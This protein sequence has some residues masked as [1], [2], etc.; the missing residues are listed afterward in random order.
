MNVNK[1]TGGEL[2]QRSSLTLIANMAFKIKQVAK[3]QQLFS[4]FLSTTSMVGY[5]PT[6]KSCI[7]DGA[8]PLT[9]FGQPPKILMYPKRIPRCYVPKVDVQKI[10]EI[11]LSKLDP[12][13]QRVWSTTDPD[14]WWEPKN[15]QKGLH[16]ERKK[17]LA[18][19]VT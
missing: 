19:A 14:S 6:R 10:S 15:I 11:G 12:K 18:T 2:L 3:D 4:R 9:I 17:F 13:R 8:E 5:S 16:E 7:P 1:S